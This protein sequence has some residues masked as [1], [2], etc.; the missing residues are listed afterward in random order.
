MA[1]DVSICS[2]ALLKL[3]DKPIAT[4]QEND[5]RAQLCANIYP[6]A[7]LDVL[8]S[9]PWNCAVKRVLLAPLAA[10]PAFSWRFQFTLPGELLRLMQVGY[11]GCQ[12]DYQLEG[13]RILANTN[14]LPILY[15]A[16]ITEGLFDA[17][18][19]HVMTL[20]ME[21]DLAYPITKSTSLAEAKDAEYERALKRAK[22]ID[23]QETPPQDWGDSPFTQVRGGGPGYGY[24]G[25]GI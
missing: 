11:D 4:L 17:K 3:G 20:R 13:G 5:R 2:A 7:K 9:H 15:V 1:T 18:L 19:V 24:S 10:P 16:D 14:S 8:R 12:L 21:K 23:G 22:S 25:R 6:L